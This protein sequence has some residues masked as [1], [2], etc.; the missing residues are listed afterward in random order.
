[1][2]RKIA[3][4]ITGILLLVL[5][6]SYIVLICLDIQYKN[7]LGLS[8]LTIY[9]IGTIIGDMTNTKKEFKIAYLFSVLII[10]IKLLLNRA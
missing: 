1:M 2:R 8:I 5:I 7:W 10:S 3:I 6:I 9:P 4:V